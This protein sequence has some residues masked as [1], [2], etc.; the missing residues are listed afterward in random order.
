MSISEKILYYRKQRKLS[1]RA[2]A[3]EVGVTASY[4]S[5]IERNKSSPSINTLR[6]IADALDV[7]VFDFLLEADRE[8]PV[9]RRNERVR[10]HPPHSPVA[11]ELLTPD[12]NGKNEIIIVELEPG[13]ANFAKPANCNTEECIFVLQGKMRIQLMEKEYILDNGDSIRFN[14]L[15]LQKIYSVGDQNL[16]FISVVN[17]PIF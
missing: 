11:F 9:V 6:A 10:I 16:V 15:F 2:L 14:G 12:L 8:N 4:L 7:P 1:L 5:L 17:P 13:D 3:N